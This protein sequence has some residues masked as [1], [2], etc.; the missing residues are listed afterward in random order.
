MSGGELMLASSVFSAVKTY[1][2]IQYAKAE[3]EAYKYQLKLDEDKTVLDGMIESNS[4]EEKGQ[5]QKND[6]LVYAVS[7]GYLDSSRHFLAVQDDQDRI[8]AHDKKVVSLNTT[9]AVGILQN[10]KYVDKLKTENAVFGGYLSITADLTGG[11]GKYKHY[12][13]PHTDKRYTGYGKS[14]YGR[15]TEYN[16]YDTNKYG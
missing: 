9:Y 11:Y 14:G 10:K 2:D 8:T 4:I 16:Y 13:N 15:D 12:K 5:K 3:H 1:K 7:Q 6:N